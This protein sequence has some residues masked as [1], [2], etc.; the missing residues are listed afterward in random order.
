MSLGKLMRYSLSEG[1][2][3]VTLGQ[4]LAT[5]REYLSFQCIR[6]GDR[7]TWE[8]RSDPGIEPLLI[9]RFTLQPIVENAVRHGIEP[10]VEGGRVVVSARRLRDRV[11]LVVADSGVGMDPPLLSQIRA[12][13]SGSASQARAEPGEDGRMPVCPGIGMANLELRLAYRYSGRARLAIASRPGRG[14]VIRISLPA[15]PSPEGRDDAV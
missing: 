7:L 4:E 3:F 12:A 5:L 1:K 2:S 14:T 11:R 15:A 10:K 6:F 13:A 9:P 8:I